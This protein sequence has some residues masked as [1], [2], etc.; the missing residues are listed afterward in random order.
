MKIV[1]IGTGYVGLVSGACFSE[2]GFD[3]TCIDKDPV[4]IQKINLGEMPIYE[5]GLP[6]L[7]ARNVAAGRLH[8][9]LDLAVAV[10]A[11]DAVLSRSEPRHGAVM[12][13]LIYHLSMMWQKKWRRIYLDIRWL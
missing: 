3:V 5:P 10:A 2:F 13:M 12:V 6:D 9:T 11:A 7:V 8:F 4:K 1:V